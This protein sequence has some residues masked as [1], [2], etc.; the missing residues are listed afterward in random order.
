MSKKKIQEIV[1]IGKDES[2]SSS[3]Y[4]LESI[5]KLILNNNEEVLNSQYCG[6]RTFKTALRKN[7]RKVAQTKGA[8]LWILYTNNHKTDV[9]LNEELKLNVN[10]LRILIVNVD[11]KSPVLLKEYICPLTQREISDNTRNFSPQ[12]RGGFSESR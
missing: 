5:K 8:Y 12:E 1:I 4:L 10:I 2:P 3:Q 6:V 9:I 11:P 7:G